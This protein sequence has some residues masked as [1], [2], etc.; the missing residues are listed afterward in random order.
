MLNFF[1][2][3]RTAVQCLKDERGQDMIEYVLLAALIAVVVA[4]AIPALT[5]A[6]IAE[7]GIIEGI[8]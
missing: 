4:A 8:L 1:V 5:N 7:F 2:K 6:I 3:A